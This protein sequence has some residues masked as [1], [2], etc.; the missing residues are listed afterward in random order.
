[1]EIKELWNNF[2]GKM[3]PNLEIKKKKRLKRMGV[4]TRTNGYYNFLKILKI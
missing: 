3:I 4:K 1:M 2:F